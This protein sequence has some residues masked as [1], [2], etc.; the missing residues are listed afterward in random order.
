MQCQNEVEKVHMEIIRDYGISRF[1]LYFNIMVNYFKN[2][3]LYIN[4]IEVI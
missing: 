4:Q 3:F 2:Y 1:K